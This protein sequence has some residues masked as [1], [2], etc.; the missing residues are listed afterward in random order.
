MAST[1]GGLNYKALNEAGVD[2]DRVIDFSVSINP[3][4]LP[5]EVYQAFRN[6]PIERY[7]DSSSHIL[8]KEIAAAYDLPEEELL[9]VNGTSQAVFLLAGAYLTERTPWLLAGPT[10]SEYG[11]ACRLYSQK[12]IRLDSR[13]EEGFRP[14]PERLIEAIR[15]EKPAL[16]WLCSPNNPTGTVLGEQDFHRIREAALEEGTLFILDEA[17]RCFLPEKDQYKTDFPGVVNLRS[18][19]KDF[20]IPGL[21]LGYVRASR[22]VIE[23]LARR[24]PEWSVSAPAQ[25]AGTAALKKLAYFQKSWRLVTEMTEEFRLSVAEAGY[26]TYPTGSNFFLVK[27]PDLEKLKKRLWEEFILVRDCASFGLQNIM[28]LGTRSREDNARLVN[29]LREEKIS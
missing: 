10:Y 3:E 25:E 12:E 1:H 5:Q 6:A 27:V 14:S 4:P 13:E 8:K 29:I 11:D 2:P 21:R 19:T 9:V 18:M 22:E 24:Q 16:L 23:T 26:E 7:P 17:Y 28:R 20:S 15:R